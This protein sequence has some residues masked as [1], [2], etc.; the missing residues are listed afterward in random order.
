[1]AT[2]QLGQVLRHLK[3]VL[4]D[5]TD[6]QL[7]ERFLAVRDEQ[8]F[9]ALVRRHGPMVLGVC[10]RVLGNAHDAEDSFQATFLVLARR[11]ASVRRRGALGSWLYGVARHMALHARRA[12]A[13]RRAKEANAMPRPETQTDDLRE[14]L[15]EELGRLPDKYR[16]LLVLCD[17]EG[18][19]R[20][21][22]ARQLGLPQGTVASR[23]ARGRTLL[24]R[25]LSRHGPVLSGGAL[26][27]TLS[28]AT[29]TVPA[30]LVNATVKAAVLVAAGQ[31]AAVTTPAVAL[32]KEVQ[33][34]MLLTKL[35]LAVAA[36]MVAALVGTG[37]LLYQAAGQP[38]LAEK[39]APGRAL[40]EVE[41]L[42]REVEILKLQVEVIQSELRSLKGHA[43]APTAPGKP[44][45]SE[46]NPY[47]L[48]E[49]VKTPV[50]K[51]PTGY[52]PVED[53]KGNPF[54]VA[55]APGPDPVQE[56]EIALKAM[57]TAEKAGDA[58]AKEHALARMGAAL[59]RLREQSRAKNYYEPQKH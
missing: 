18:R 43:A 40:T 29:A 56:V 44:A 55:P 17:L 6:G 30:P 50:G 2:G 8:A 12:A 27:V 14:V 38:P 3:G 9:E 26:A 46:N 19:T 37:S 45:A 25:R 10:R 49:F 24:A 23:L 35:K 4:D 58:A 57:L 34:V 59:Q 13:R 20:Q 48:G 39:P 42:R 21:E 52:P 7:L 36:V 33:K 22:A 15:D 11:A 32:M 54:G 41:L 31:A 16:A 53:P 1:M 51:A 47:R 28:E 5:A